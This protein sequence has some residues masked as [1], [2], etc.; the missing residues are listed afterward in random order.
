MGLQHLAEFIVALITENAIGMCAWVTDNQ[1]AC[2][3]SC[4]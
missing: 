1:G 4:Q 2:M 3:G